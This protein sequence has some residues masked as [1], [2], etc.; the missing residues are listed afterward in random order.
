MI[1]KESL[2]KGFKTVIAI[3]MLL[4]LIFITFS[5]NVQ[6]ETA[7]EK[8][9]RLE[10]EIAKAKAN[11]KDVKAEITRSVLAI[12][13]LKGQIADKDREIAELEAEINETKKEVDKISGDLAKEEE[14]Y[15][16]Q[17]EVVKKRITFMY[18]SGQFK[19]WEILLKSNGIMDF[20][21]NYYMLQEISKLDNEILSECSRNKRK[22]EVLK[23]E[24]ESKTKVLK[25]NQDRV[26]KSKIVQKNLMTLKEANVQKLNKQEKSILAKIDDLAAQERAAEREIARELASYLG[27][28]QY[29]G[30]EFAWPVPG[31]TYISTYYGDGPAQG[32]Y[33]A[34]PRGHQGLDIADSRNTPIVAANAGVVILSE[35]YGG[36]GNCVIIDHGGG[37]ITLYGHGNKR[38]VSKGQIVTRGQR[39]MLMGDTGFSFGDHLHFELLKNARTYEPKKRVNPLPYVTH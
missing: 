26:E 35:Y 14:D 31:C 8:K 9:A 33:W 38:L 6:A 7:R 5:S 36:Y 1:T 12:M 18:E 3:I 4:V 37:Y 16:K 22:I 29:V 17:E 2:K 32:Y 25:D 23:K 34:G 24:L 11:Q 20:L 28:A 27:N 13:E 15:L 19:T 39:I 10:K 21:S 30:G